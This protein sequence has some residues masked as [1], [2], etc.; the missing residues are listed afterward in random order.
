MAGDFP[1]IPARERV[2]FTP[3]VVSVRELDDDEVQRWTR[4]WQAP[5]THATPTTP[6]SA[7]WFMETARKSAG[8]PAPAP[9]PPTTT[10]AL[11]GTEST[12]ETA[13]SLATAESASPQ[14]K[15]CP[16]SCASTVAAVSDD[17]RCSLW[18]ARE[19]AR[20][21]RD[22]AERAAYRHQRH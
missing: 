4:G 6:S 12:P 15:T 1:S 11:D 18:L 14:H 7:L 20:R 9:L 17:Q 22:A 10:P 5:N 3:V 21:Q 13:D 8:V 2:P 19:H 16:A